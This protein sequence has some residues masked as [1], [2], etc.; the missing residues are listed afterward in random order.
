MENKNVSSRN[1]SQKALRLN[2]DE[3]KYG[4]IVEIGAGQEVAR[5]FFL[6]G[7]AAG[8]IA[9]TM[10]AYDMKFS[11]AI[12]GVQND[13]RYVSKA[14]VKAMMEQE[15][16]LV[17][18]RVA[19]IRSISSRYFAYAATVS[20]KSFNK[21]NECHAW[22]GVRVQMYPGAEPSNIELHVRMHDDNAEAQ[23][24]ALGVLGVNLIYAAYY[25]FENPKLMIDSLTDNIK[26]GRLEIDS[27]EFIVP[28]FEDLDNRAIN[29]HLI[30]SW[31]TRAVMFRPD[32]SISV[33]SEMLY[34]K[35]VITIRGAFRPLTNLNRDMIEQGKKAFF[36]QPGV[37]EE[38]T[39][40]IA[41]IS[42]NDA[43]GN[44][45]H[46]PEEDL[47]QRVQILNALGYNVMISDYTRYFSLRA[48]FRQYTKME[49]GIV[50]GMANLKQIFD[51]DSYVGVKGGILEG[52]GKL[53]PDNTRMFI[54]PEL[55]VSGEL[56]DYKNHKVQEHLRFLY[57][58]LLENDFLTGLDASDVELF[59]IYSRDILKQLKSGRGD[60]EKM[61]PDLVAEQIIEHGFFGFKKPRK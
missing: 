33:P 31:K 16:D 5:Q 30:R 7:A 50:V 20:A 47:I 42:L 48:Y 35:N 40:A 12:Y 39:I 56:R 9:K 28:Y 46:V 38:N 61:V 26:Q 60:W 18:E 43:K 15:L 23:Q 37:N 52:F 8:T 51:E 21:L 4:T 3:K 10:S 25:Y 55:N 2:L 34:K 22:V 57:R 59:K 32:G 11:D 29:L 27:I 19:D 45:N 13:G 24:Q 58:H 49:I 17:I 1:T 14:R 54:Y 53:F 44:D 36:E 6:A 41:E